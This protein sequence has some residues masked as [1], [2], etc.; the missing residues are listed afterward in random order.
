M[1]VEKVG[2]GAYVIIRS[3]G[4]EELAESVDELMSNGYRPWQ[5]MQVIPGANLRPTEYLQ[6]V[7][8]ADSS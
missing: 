2:E 8:K 5:S 4:L 1:S 6:V 7:V 3:D